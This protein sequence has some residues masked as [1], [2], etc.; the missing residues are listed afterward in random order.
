MKVA[1]RADAS[2][3]IG[4]GHVMRCLTL[5]EMLREKGAE[6][7]VVCAQH[8]GHM[9]ALIEERGIPVSRLPM[10]PVETIDPAADAEQTIAAL[11]AMDSKPDWMIVDHYALGSSWEARIRSVVGN[12]MAID[13]LADRAHDCDILLDQNLVA[14]FEHRYD[15][16]VRPNAI[17]LL[18]PTYALLQPEYRLLRE[19]SRPRNSPA[20]HFLVYFGGADAAGMTA[21]TVAALIELGRP[22]ISADIVIGPSNPHAEAVHALAAGHANLDVHG[23]KA[24]LA[25][26]MLRADMAIGA[27]GA[28][29]WER[30][31]LGLPAIVVTLADNQRPIAAELDRLGLVR[32]LGDAAEVGKVELAAAIGHAATHATEAESAATVDGWGAS[33]VADEILRHESEQPKIRRATADD[34]DL[35]F[36]WANEPEARRQSFN[37]QPIPYESHVEWFNLKLS[38]PGCHMF[39]MIERGMPVGQIRFDV[40][41]GVG[42]IAYSLDASARGRGLAKTLV[43]LG[44]AEM[45]GYGVHSFSAKV[46]DGNEPSAAVFLRCGFTEGVA[47]G[48][49]IFHKR[50]QPGGDTIPDL[51]L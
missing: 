32:W 17:R 7:R 10:G 37:S 42:E 23:M 26:L 2:G 9:I 27:T 45:S 19:R 36:H 14:N 13:D 46:K 44:I 51:Q 50:I 3:M 16:L 38:A 35:F 21:R 39:V 25:E 43:R 4:S 1:I 30:L 24:S 15:E 34:L 31:C 8:A 22:D 48:Y 28:T 33:R 11:V 47:S 41:N 20:R 29:S 18:G 12:I 5:A 49:R 40:V 6:P